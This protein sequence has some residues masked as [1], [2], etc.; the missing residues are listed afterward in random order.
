MIAVSIVALFGD[1][2]AA[3]KRRRHASQA[4]TASAD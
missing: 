3:A 2:R 4:A 1:R